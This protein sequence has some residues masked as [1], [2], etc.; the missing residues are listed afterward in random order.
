MGKNGVLRQ[1]FTVAPQP[2]DLGL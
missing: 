2:G 1:F